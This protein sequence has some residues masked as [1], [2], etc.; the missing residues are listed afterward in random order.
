MCDGLEA[1]HRRSGDWL[2]GMSA[3]DVVREPAGPQ[4]AMD[5]ARKATVFAPLLSFSKHA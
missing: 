3:P 1:V 2:E 5:A 4:P